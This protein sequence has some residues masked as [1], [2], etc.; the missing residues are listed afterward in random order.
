MASLQSLHRSS[1]VRNLAV[2]ML[3]MSAVLLPREGRATG[4][5]VIGQVSGFSFAIANGADVGAATQTAI[6]TCRSN[7]DA[8]NNPALKADCKVVAT[9]TDK[10]A[11]VAWDPAPNYAGVGVGW[12]IAAD[13]KT[14]EREAI[15]K[16]EKTVAPGRSGTC[17]VSN[18]RCDGNAQ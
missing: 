11:V 12:S 1:A 15:A 2:A 18:S 6:D 17:V 8:V 4:V 13:M 16:C 5:L 3:A 10:C 7:K 9:F 14:A